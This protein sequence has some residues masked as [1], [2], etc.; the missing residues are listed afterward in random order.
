MPAS[1]STSPRLRAYQRHAAQFIGEHLPDRSASATQDA[2]EIALLCERQSPAR[3]VSVADAHCLEA[4]EQLLGCRGLGDIVTGRAELCR[5][6]E[7]QDLGEALA[8]TSRAL[9]VTISGALLILRARG[10]SCSPAVD[11][12]LGPLCLL[13]LAPAVTRDATA[14]W[15]SRLKLGELRAAL[16]PWPGIGLTAM[17]ARFETPFDADDALP[18]IA[19]RLPAQPRRSA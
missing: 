18:R 12:T 9:R 4:L 7:R 3:W 8:V 14:A 16:A 15:L 10:L 17:A 13:A 6:D 11:A 5:L 2:T 1:P 19:A